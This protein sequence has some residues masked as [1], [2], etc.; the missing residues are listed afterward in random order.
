MQPRIGRSHLALLKRPLRAAVHQF[1]N[2]YT[3]PPDP[4][5]YACAYGNIDITHPLEIQFRWDAWTAPDGDLG[6]HPA[7]GGA[8]PCCAGGGPYG[9]R[10]RYHAVSPISGRNLRRARVA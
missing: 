10:L 1:W 4:S 8:K 2:L 9:G 7:L 6:G 3:T 5:P